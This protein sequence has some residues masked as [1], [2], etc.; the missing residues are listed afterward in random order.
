MVPEG[1]YGIVPIC[2]SS[3]YMVLGPNGGV[4]FN[5]RKCRTV[6]TA[7]NWIDKRLKSRKCK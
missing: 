3:Q 5:L 6:E 4:V 2:G 7:K 1:E